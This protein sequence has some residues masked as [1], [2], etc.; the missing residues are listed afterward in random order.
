MYEPPD[1][2][3]QKLDSY[4]LSD[5]S[6][7][8]SDWN[9]WSF[10]SFLEFAKKRRA[11]S[12]K[13]KRD[14]HQRFLNSLNA[15]LMSDASRKMHSTSVDLFWKEVQTNEEIAVAQAEYQRKQAF[16]ELKNGFEN[17]RHLFVLCFLIPRVIE[18]REREVEKDV[19]KALSVL[20]APTTPLLGNASTASSPRYTPTTPP[21]NASTT[22]QP[23]SQNILKRSLDIYETSYEMDWAPWKFDI[24]ISNVNIE[25]VLMSLHEKCQKTKPK[26]KTSLEYGIIDLN[27]GI[28]LEAL[29]QSVISHFEAKMQEY[30]PKKALSVEVMRIL[31]TFNV[32]SLEDLGKALDEVK[33]DY[34]NLDRDIIY[35]RRLFEK[36]FL[37][38]QDKSTINLDNRDLPEGWYNSHIVAPIFD[39]CLESMDECILRRGEV[40]SF[41][42]KLLD[43]KSRK[44]KKY[45]GILS[46]SR[47][48]EFIYV[49][50]AT[51]SVLSKS[52][53]DLSKLHNA[54]ILMFKHMVSTLPEKLLHEISS[55]PILCV[56]FSG[57]SVEVYLAI[58]LANMRPVVFS[59]MD[60][61][62]AE[63]ITTFPKMTKVAAKMLSL[64]PFIQ[65]L[66]KRYQT[67][68][69]KE[70]DHYLDDDN[71]WA[72]PIRMKARH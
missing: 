25:C 71:T 36:F 5:D 37:L 27:D 12:I 63:E 3:K 47:Q 6:S 31:K 30:K 20:D 29:G 15:I 16:I 52:D 1:S 65:D 51:T 23:L 21:R 34:N 62:I 59:I 43:K 39:D 22:P 72:S 42:Q 28:I 14:L 55:M 68:L 35:L 69:T 56:Q 17:V 24:T 53:K 64:R 60:F 19:N 61:E 33:I 4:F 45:D 57:A 11:L 58:W 54:I 7:S 9:N 38:F 32:T 46:F 26:T 66:H 2:L 18:S 41:V 48:F 10:L 40:E 8:L 44:K 67:L 70:A 50:T 13:N 49:E